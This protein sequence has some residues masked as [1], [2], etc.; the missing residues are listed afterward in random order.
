[1]TY[2]IFVISIAYFGFKQTKR[3]TLFCTLC[4]VIDTSIRYWALMFDICCRTLPCNNIS[5]TRQDIPVRI[6]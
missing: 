2:A 5:P 3:N 6:G 4:V 1:M